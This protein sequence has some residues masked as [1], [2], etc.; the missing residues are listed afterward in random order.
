MFR[1]GRDSLEI[2]FDL[3]QTWYLLILEDSRITTDLRLAWAS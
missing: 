3:N 2:E 1:V